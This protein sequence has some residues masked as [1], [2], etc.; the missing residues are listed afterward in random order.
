M[1]F[2]IPK[3]CIKIITNQEYE[4]G[5]KVEKAINKITGYKNL[6]KCKYVNDTSCLNSKKN[7]LLYAAFEPLTVG[8]YVVVKSKNHGL[9]LAIVIE[10]CDKEEKQRLLSVGTS[11]EREVCCK[12]DLEAYETRVNSRK[13]KLE[14][15]ELLDKRVEEKNKIE[16]YERLCGDDPIAKELLNELKKL[17]GE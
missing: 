1:S 5:L 7:N 2:W 10:F 15:E 12:C 13:R 11:I 14:L 6:V 17:S 4:E 9:G 8:D 16:R 3:R